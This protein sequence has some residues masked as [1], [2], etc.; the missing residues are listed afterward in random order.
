MAFRFPGDLAAEAD[1][2]RALRRGSDLVGRIGPERWSTDVL[3]HPKRSEAG[4]SITFA[5]GVLSRID[6]FD[7]GFFGISPREA[8]WLDPQQRLLL[9][10]AW[11]AMEAGGQVPSAL[12]GS[13]CAVY[14][15]ISAVDYGMRAMDDLSAVTA[16]SM[17]G[18]TLS[19]AAN[20]LSY[21]FDLRGPSAAVD[22]ACSSSLV[23]LHHACNSLRMGEASA[24]LVGGVNLLLHPFPFVGFTKASML[25]ASG[26]CRAFDAAADG[27]VRAEGG[28]VVLLKPLDKALADGDAVQAVIVASGTNTDGGRKSGITI[29]S[30]EGQANLMREVLARSGLAADDVAY[31]EAHGTGTPIGDPIEAAAIG[32]VYGRSGT[33]GSALP[34]G[35]V[36]TNLGHLESAS[37][38]AGLIKAILIL[39]NRALPPSLHLTTP[40][41]HIDFAG[42]N[43]E[44]VTRYRLLPKSARK[45]LAVGVNSF[46][47][48]GANAHVLLQQHRP[49]RQAPRRIKP[50]VPPLFLSARTPQALRELAGRYANQIRQ[51]PTAYYDIAHAAAYRRERLE[52]RLALPAAGAAE[53]ASQLADFAKGNS[54][55][56]LVL[57]DALVQPGK[58]AFVYSGNGAQWQGMG[59]KLLV[60][61]SRFAA[62]IAELDALIGPLA[63]F[64]IHEE[65]RAAQQDARLEDTSV[66]QPVLFA[67]QVAL[68]MLL[69]ERG[70]EAD[71]VAGHSA[72]EVAAAWA[73]GALSLDQAAA[74]ICA[75]SAAQGATRGAGRM[76]A[77]G[78]TEAAARELIAAERLAGIEISGINS[79]TSVTLSGDL[80][81][82][83]HLKS[84]LTQRNVFY[85]LLEFDYAFHSRSMDPIE[86]D[87]LARVATLA[88]QSAGGLP[89]IS[90]VT[91]GV[92]PGSALGTKYWWRNVREPVNFAG[93]MSALADFGCR[94][95]LEI[96]PNA[97]L[98]RFMTEC[99]TA[100][101]VGGR[102][103]PTM[104]RGH[105]GLAGIDE[106][107]L[108][109]QLLAESPRLDVF[110]P[111][112]ARQ[113]RLPAYP[114]Q[115]E[116]H[117]HPRSSEGYALI[118]RARVHPLLGWRLKEAP[119]AWEN[120]LD[121]ESSPWLADHKVGDATVLPGAAF[122]EMAL[123]ASREYFGG[124]RHE[125][126]ALNIL[127]PIVFD[128]EHARSIR[129]ELSARDGNFQILSRQRLSDDEWTR[130]AAGRLRLAAGGVEPAAAIEDVR[131]AGDAVLIDHATHYRL[132]DALGL[133]YGPSFRGLTGARVRGQCL[134]ASVEL[135][136]AQR[137]A[138]AQFMIHPALLDV[139]FQSLVGFFQGDIDSQRS[140]PVLPVK[141]GRLRYFLAAPVVRF[142]AC[143]RRRAERSV[144][145]DFEL[146][147]ASDR[148]VATLSDCR[149]R[150]APLRRRG[151]PRPSCWTI[152]PQLQ[153]LAAEALRAEL[154]P[155]AE[156]AER[157]R[158]WF[159]GEEPSLLRND[160]F[161]SALPLFEALTVSFA[162]DAFQELFARQGEWME[163]ALTHPET[164]D[165]AVRPFFR[166][167]AG[168]LR[169]EGLLVEQPGGW[170][171][172]STDLPSA[173]SIW[174]TLLRDCPANLP[175]LVFAARV[176]RRLA[177][178]LSN[179]EEARLLTEQLRLSHQ[180]EALYQDSSSYLGTRLAVEQIVGNVAA[181]W[182]QHRRLRVLEIAVGASRVVQRL[183]DCFPEERLD[184]V[185]ANPDEQTRSRLEAEFST[186][187]SV[188]VASI[189]ADSLELVA[190][191][192]LPAT[193]DVIV[194]SHWLH[195][196]PHPVGVLAAVRRQLAPGGLLVVAER[197]PDLA[198]DF[199]GGLDPGWWQQTATGAPLSRLQPPAAWQAALAKQAFVDIEAFCEP[200]GANL[201]EGAYVLL[202]KRAKDEIVTIAEP[203][204]AAWLLVCDGA[205]PWPLLGERLQRLI[206]SRGHR[207]LSVD[208]AAT[209]DTAL[210][211]AHTALGK[212][213]H[214]V[215]LSGAVDSSLPS[216][217]VPS[218]PQDSGGLVGALG[219][220]QA[221]GRNPTPPRLWLVTHGGA[222]VERLPDGGP[223][224]LMQG[225]L[226]GFGRVVMNEYPA[227]NCTLVDLDID[228]ASDAAAGRLQMELLH[229]D[230]E[231][232]VM[233]GAHG[234]YVARV[235]NVA[236]VV[237]ARTTGPAARFRLDFH[238]PG[239][240]SNL[241]WQPQS[242]RTLGQDEIEVRVVAT[243]L[244]FR[245]V[246]YLQGLLPEDAI[247]GGFAGASLG[248]EFA[249]VVSRVGRLGGEFVVGDAVMGFGSGCFASHV[250]TRANAITHKPAGWSFESAA[251]VPT[252][253]FTVYHSLKHLAAL[254]SGERIL[255]HG[256][257]G[258]V[259]IAA[260]QFA[261][262][263][264]AEVFATA[265]SDEKRD[266]V[267]LLGA[268]HVLDS[269]TLAF[270]DQIMAMT[271]G[272]GVDV[273]LNSLAGEALRRSLD[274]LKPFGRFLELGKRDF[275]ENT[276]IGLRPLRNNISYFGIDADQLL[277]ARP[278]LTARLFREVMALFREKVLFP[279]PYR[280][281][282]A[283][284]IV[285]AFRTM[286]QAQQIGKVI[287]RMEGA[288]VAME[289][290]PALVAPLRFEPGSSWLISGGIAG[291]GLESARWLAERGVGHLVLVGRRGMRTPGAAEAVRSLEALGARVEVVACDISERSAV[292][293]MLD[294]IR[295]TG[296]PLTGVL[297]AAMVLDDGLIANLD[298]K[299][300]R[301]VL[302][303]KMLGAWHLHELTLDIPIEYFVLYSSITTLIGNPG[304][305]NYVAANAGLESLALLRRAV[306]L[307]VTC[308]GWGP[309]GDAGYLT[310]NQAVKD[311]LAGRLGANPLSARAA[312]GM[313]NQLLPRST[314]MV[315]V[316]DFDWPKLARLLPAA[317]A[318]R[319]EWLRRRAG[320]AACEDAGNEDIRVMIAGKTRAEAVQIAQA[321]VVHEVAQV[322]SVAADRVDPRRSVHDLG[323]DSLMAVE[324][325]MGL[326]K[327]LGLELPAMLLS[328]GVTVERVAVRIIDRLLSGEEE[329]TAKGGDQ[330][331]AIAATLAAQHGESVD[332]DLVVDTLEQVRSQDPGKVRLTR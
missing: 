34:I 9:E 45:A 106:A 115:R 69:R 131:D 43:I 77:V 204:S 154:P 101:S 113:V 286:Q 283:A 237:P 305:A 64:S 176:G 30:G 221:I 272:E 302:A 322:L 245:D 90:T 59:Q 88:P 264:G 215:Y 246:M 326:E 252:V 83:D 62:L 42:L 324:L 292:Q 247:E 231:Q 21:A 26:R 287:V 86:R 61:S 71:A 253:F 316:G 72:G 293:A 1:L 217:D 175:E 35:S 196:T 124:A 194:L 251:T 233:L 162:R 328:E 121:P 17:T 163:R 200:A 330:F 39:K 95:F 111:Q 228:P 282:P 153:P 261:L 244:N 70:I 119:A 5:A 87:L 191:A 161:K 269:R 202:A 67:I 289:A 209:A 36:K 122:A 2:W 125:F 285:D 174:R 68:T 218:H 127:V 278:E 129:F 239:R 165:E 85:R 263:L 201:S 164:I 105:D 10:L 144:L 319:F 185:I 260:I 259:G 12:A 114:W 325:V 133:H 91:G 31:I 273:V 53:S 257:A 51:T 135:P 295:N 143:L 189:N 151:V 147:D 195:R 81:A 203:A 242:E 93:A 212:L 112:P 132:T 284:S 126:E 291:F 267:A 52:R 296:T 190:D 241:L 248:L 55:P 226:W 6:E 281:Y 50:G 258:G 33:R 58:V 20:R 82:L 303:P 32:A 84:L 63:G 313:L 108:R 290:A 275:F 279:L 3:Q 308:I 255:I 193:Y 80:A 331:D 123:A 78:L 136:A 294:E 134:S 307:P 229:P 197:H 79:P 107:A 236:P 98:Q 73:G 166:W 54:V 311:S 262:H 184:Y 256:G 140:V 13:D 170:R 48:G 103:L 117:W 150:A 23:A 156:M 158:R 243:G 173:Q 65:L 47:F 160:Y 28:A 116:R 99:L 298:A 138:A 60:E 309:I 179:G 8:A 40:N 310:R 152:V 270:A 186:R 92:L 25:S 276:P 37:G 327:R 249:G 297:H 235:Q 27:Y 222:L 266:F 250:I 220:V 182:P 323:M 214:V 213:D 192:P 168:V 183:L 145:A 318:A 207:A 137:A 4:R 155:N 332:A 46:G 320:P 22:T 167:L 7:A 205:A 169:G 208:A 149:F 74:L 178:L 329:G 146:L 128:G 172:E 206:E 57:E 216:G 198:A 76:A 110:F 315:A 223:G 120:A 96:G 225:A 271:N 321:L 187:L 18:N 238:A 66:A 306:G 142:R 89:F 312:L 102:V 188:R 11:E 211:R 274:V 159:E 317:N 148:I 254:Q 104:R 16:H 97:I 38:M 171:L 118:T 100:A 14:V 177:G 44:V 219:L 240:M 141:F 15:G 24:A 210:S 277:I 180:A 288:T 181:D 265:G 227:L 157:L 29:P 301:G 56:Q 224:N 304:Q 232:E 314:G 230:G 280:L 234:R 268:D 94:V 130:N 299:R 199:V 139:C 75:R 19:I 41:P 109:V 49:R 300:L